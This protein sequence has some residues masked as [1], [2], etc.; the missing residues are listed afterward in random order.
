MLLKMD[1]ALMALLFVTLFDDVDDATT[2]LLL[3]PLRFAAFRHAA[4]LSRHLLDAAFYAAM[5]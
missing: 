2:T 3:L 4:I 1:S 5:S